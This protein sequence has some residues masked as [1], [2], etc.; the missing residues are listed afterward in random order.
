MI[1][2]SAQLECRF[3]SILIA[4]LSGLM[5][6]RRWKQGQ[7]LT[8]AGGLHV[9][10]FLMIG[11][12]TFCYSLF[13]DFSERY[14]YLDITEGFLHSGWYWLSGYI[15][16]C[17]YEVNQ[18]SPD[19]HQD[20]D[21]FMHTSQMFGIVL[22]S[23]SFLGYLVCQTEFAS[24]GIG[25]IFVVL[26]G[27]LYPALILTILSVRTSKPS[28][29][30]AMA[31][32]SLLTTYYALFSPWRSEIVITSGSVAI[33]LL[34]RNRKWLLPAMLAMTFALLILIPFAN[35]KKLHYDEYLNDPVQAFTGTLKMDMN[36]RAEFVARFFS[37]R[38]DAGRE[39][40]YVQHAIDK[41]LIE[42]RDGI[43]YWEA[44]QQLVPRVL[45]S[46]KPSFNMIMNFVLPR[47]IGM[48]DWN[49]K[50]TSWGVSLYAE[51]LWNFNPYHLIWFVPLIFMLLSHVDGFID[52]TFIRRGST[53]ITHVVL[54]FQ[55]FQI[56]GLVTQISYVL[57]A[58]LVMKAAERVFYEA[59]SP[60]IM[61]REPGLQ[62]NA[63]ENSERIV[64]TGVE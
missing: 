52:R 16:W 59:P 6:S 40:G 54:F 38:I 39:M 46:D 41:S 25:T 31:L 14:S 10:A 36:E 33:A 26:K 2:D 62:F 37:L 45:W 49:D 64:V 21:W 27:F 28:S 17:L 47:Q 18:A 12:G 60:S 13:D 24:S 29:V 63:S 7:L 23:L 57:W 11:C 3:L 5:I 53:F 42:H 51:L 20:N 35:Y 55:I 4:V 32:I 1:F 56:V 8:A 58:I 19:S 9:N 22:A 50:G 61:R 34:L 15:L 30:F 44:A 48:V 43:S